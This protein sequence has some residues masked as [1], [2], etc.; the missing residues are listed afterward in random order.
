[1]EV[2]KEFEAALNKN[3]PEHLY[4]AGQGLLIPN[5]RVASLDHPRHLFYRFSRP[6]QDIATVDDR[7]IDMVFVL[8]S[9]ESD[10]PLHL[11]RLSRLTRLLQDQV[12]ARNLREIEKSDSVRGQFMYPDL[13]TR[14]A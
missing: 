11:R 9:P 2:W 13:D 1:M 3:E 4:S 8:L 14:A 6:F 7:N 10:G 12:F 5:A